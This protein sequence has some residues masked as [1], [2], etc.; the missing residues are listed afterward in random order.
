MKKT[1][2]K[3]F[4]LTTVLAVIAIS[5]ATAAPVGMDNI[6]E[7]YY[8]EPGALFESSLNPL[9]GRYQEDIGLNGFG[10]YSKWCQTYTF[11]SCNYPNDASILLSD[12]KFNADILWLDY[13]NCIKPEPAPVPEPRT[14]ALL[15]FG[16]ISAGIMLRKRILK[17]PTA[18]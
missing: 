7:F 9:D 15:G 3:S 1:F 14:I 12:V 8:S 5:G 10:D 13:S 6:K 11:N 2:I 18:V 17:N 16:L 4:L